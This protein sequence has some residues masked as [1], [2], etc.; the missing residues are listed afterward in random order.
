[1]SEI[2]ISC[3]KCMQKMLVD[4]EYIGMVAQCPNPNCQSEFLIT[5]PPAPEPPIQV[6]GIKSPYQTVPQQKSNLIS[7][8]S[9]SR[10]KSSKGGIP[11]SKMPVKEREKFQ[12]KMRKFFAFSES[13]SGGAI[14]GIIRI[15]TSLFGGRK[16]I[17]EMFQQ[18]EI[19][20][21]YFQE[22]VS[23]WL[24]VDPDELSFADPIV[25]TGYDFADKCGSRKLDDLFLE[26]A[27]DKEI[28][29][30]N[31]KIWI[32][33]IV[34]IVQIAFSEHILH[35]SLKYISLVSDTRKYVSDEYFYTD[36]VNVKVESYLQQYAGRIPG[37]LK[38]LLSL[39]RRV[40]IIKLFVPKQ[41]FLL[42]EFNQA[43][44]EVSSGNGVSFSVPSEQKDSIKAMKNLIKQRK[45]A[46]QG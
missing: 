31:K 32:S 20:Q 25:F 35:C 29:Y 24:G 34:T 19:E 18:I 22:E 28:K 43:S 37:L 39:L 27:I 4:A 3:P 14:G 13:N 11:L 8:N 46:V 15:I 16:D 12:K 17:Q 21:K 36:I 38:I 42:K 10:Q 44:I 40:P 9:Y 7:G 26:W 2:K 6:P 45:M 41:K 33:P 1:M 30:N 5:A 23:D